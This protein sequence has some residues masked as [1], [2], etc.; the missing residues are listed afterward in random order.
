MTEE[1]KEILDYLKPKYDIVDELGNDYK[2]VKFKNCKLLLDY[3]TNLQ[4]ENDELKESNKRL[5]SVINDLKKPVNY[6][7]YASKYV[8]DENE[9]LKEQLQN[10]GIVKTCENCE[11]FG[12]CPHSYREY[13][14]KS[15]CEKAIEYIHKMWLAK[16]TPDTVSKTKG[17]LLNIL[18][19]SDEE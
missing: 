11:W 8:K 19:G 9:R 2:K 18:Q 10:K 7:Q 3:I 1:I 6:Y 12:T 4:Q 13:D 14:Y 17:D 16:L 5:N 15:R